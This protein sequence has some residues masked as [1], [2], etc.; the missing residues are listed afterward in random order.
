MSSLA[1]DI[2]P[3][4]NQL[5]DIP[6]RK[7]VDRPRVMLI[8]PPQQFYHAAFP[9]GPRL[10]IPIGL[11]SLGS[12]LQKNGIE[13]KIYDAFVEGSGFD[14]DSEAIVKEQVDFPMNRSIDGKA[15]EEKEK[16]TAGDELLHFGATFDE[17]RDAIASY[18]PDIVAITNLFREN[19]NETLE[20]A[21]IARQVQ[22]DAVIAIGGPN[23][24]ADA[25]K[26]LNEAPA[27]DLI[28]LGDG[29]HILLEL[30][31]WKKGKRALHTIENLVYRDA[32]DRFHRTE[33]RAFLQ[34]LDS[35][36]EL[37]YKLIRLD[38]YFA[39][40]K[41]G[42][43]S[44][45]RFEYSGGERSVSLVNSRGC[46]Y[47]CTFCSIHIH[48][49]RKF[50]TY[51]EEHVL[52]HLQNLVENYGVKHIHFEDDNLTL[53]R[54]RF[55]RIMQGVLDRGLKFTWD[56]PNGVFA[57]TLDEEMLQMM[58]KT[59]CVY[60]VIG[61][62]SGDQDVL[63]NVIK[64]KPLT[65]KKIV[66]VFELGKKVG[67]DMHAFYIIGF[68]RESMENIMTTL[69]F[70]LD[71]L[72]KWD[73]IPHLAVARAD[74]GTELYRE[75][76]EQGYLRTNV[77]MANASGVHADRFVRHTIET[78]EFT[79]KELEH[80]NEKYH[81]K[82]I[83]VIMLKTALFLLKHPRLAAQS[84]GFLFRTI[85]HENYTFRQTVIKLFFC[86]LFYRNAMTR[87]R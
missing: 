8:R 2:L 81:R 72:K 65:I 11:L 23:A 30:V 76:E 86:R 38:R 61:V 85:R 79:T 87:I 55:M 48:A 51:S 21:K 83:R 67:L 29:E 74:P 62:E 42:I 46:P 64:K 80:L 9:R 82:F 60:L 47:K 25:E 33:K 26:M 75:A 59:G 32:D 41:A 10:S 4:S 68:P 58:K 16:N 53:D 56:T 6:P 40:E 37:N 24:N 1:V 57:N 31:D 34:D 66:N 63:D 78:S 36:G 14:N 70:A 52:D 73:V 19:T 77:E 50:R 18:Q 71:S 13:V 43:M 17:M 45:A 20:C 3:D 49:G 54:P 27:I 28:G 7:V 12:F 5:P 44:R 22:P 84:M 15:G 69:N 39:Y 35:L